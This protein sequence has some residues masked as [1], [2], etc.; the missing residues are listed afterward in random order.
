MPD[1]RY[2]LAEATAMLGDLF[3]VV[4]EAREAREVLVELE[5]AERL[6]AN[7]P[8][9][10]GGTDAQRFTLA[11]LRFSKALGQLDHWDIVVRDLEEGLCDFPA[12]REGRLVYLC[13]KAGEDAIAFWHEVDEGFAGRRPVDALTP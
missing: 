2:T 3:R 4:N 9:N 12:E 10:G 1:R 13:W 8:G 11:A 5:L 6:A 7:A